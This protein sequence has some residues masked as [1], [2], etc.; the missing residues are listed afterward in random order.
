MSSPAR[1]TRS[2]WWTGRR[3][4]GASGCREPR[5]PS[6]GSPTGASSKPGSS[7]RIRRRPTPSSKE[8]S[9]GEHDDLLRRH[10]PGVK[11]DSMEQY[12][13]DSAEQWTANPGNELRRADT[14]DTRGEVLASGAQLSL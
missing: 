12:F 7:R 2:R 5:A 14:G 1:R 6:T 13:A 9:M 11:Y 10:Q 4:Y 3:R 8:G